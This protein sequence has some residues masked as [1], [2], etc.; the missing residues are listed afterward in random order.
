[1]SKLLCFI[2]ILQ[3]LT[4]L[5]SAKIVFVSERDGNREIYLMDDDGDNIQRL[6]TN[7]L[8][9]DAPAW[10]PDGMQI[11][12]HRIVT[13]GKSPVIKKS[14]ILI[15]NTDGSAQ[16]MITNPPPFSIAYYPTWSPD[17][18]NIAFAGNQDNE[19]PSSNIFVIHLSSQRVTQLTKNKE[20]GISAYGPHWSKDGKLIT[21]IQTAP[22]KWGTVYTMKSNGTNRKALIP[23][24][25]VY[26]F[27][28]RWSADGKSLLYGEGED[29]P[30]RII[31]HE[32][33]KKKRRILKTPQNWI[34]SV[35]CWMDRNYVLI[36]AYVDGEQDS[37]YDIYRYNLFTDEIKN[38]T[39]SPGH[40]TR[41]DWIHDAVLS[42]SPTDKKNIQWGK[43][44][45]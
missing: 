28:P 13:D 6:T 44:K 23:E 32:L 38:L 19:N 37:Q 4:P 10:S 12:F 21:Y 31:I 16:Q 24:D 1:M 40:D 20:S 45:K 18:K 39:N 42:V 14:D 29:G 22:R 27:S 2:F 26:R 3:V 8:K 25:G 15:M 5:A 9:D 17:G 41:Q 35:L 7:P 33:D 43:L 36:S 34:C 11:A 30:D